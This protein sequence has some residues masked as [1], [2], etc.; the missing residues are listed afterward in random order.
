VDA[1]RNK[2]P[3]SLGDDRQ[4]RALKELVGRAEAVASFQV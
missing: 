4:R 2:D 1:H 3:S